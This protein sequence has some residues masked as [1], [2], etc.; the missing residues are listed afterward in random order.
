MQARR[1]LLGPPGDAPDLLGRFALGM[2]IV[3]LQAVDI[4]TTAHM[5][6]LGGREANP[7]AA[8]LLATD[9]L[10]EAKILLAGLVGVL[11]LVAPLRRRA[12]QAVW[13]VVTFY[14]GVAAVHLAQLLGAAA[15]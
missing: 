2:A 15:A 3:V 4:V 1:L 8:W 12:Q 10:V 14:A 11:L 5:A 13:M 6:A 7:L 9:R